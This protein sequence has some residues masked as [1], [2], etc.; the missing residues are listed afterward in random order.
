[1][2]KRWLSN[3]YITLVLLFLYFP[4]SVLVT[5]SFNNSKNQ[6]AWSSFTFKWY[7]NILD[8]DRLVAALITTFS[9]AIISTLIS[10]LIG[11]FS[12]I[13]IFRMR[14][15]VKNLMLTV[16]NLPVINPDIVT[17]VS[18]MILF[19]ALGM[20]LGFVSMLI[21]HIMFSIPFVIISILPKLSQLDRN[22]F[23]AALD[24]GAT[25]MQALRKVIIPV[26]KPGIISGALI[27]FTMSIDDF[28]ISYFTTGNG[29]NNLSIWIYSQ[30]KKGVNPTANAVSTLMLLLI[31]VILVGVE[32]YE[33]KQKE[34]E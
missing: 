27:A 24:L 34:G 19:I 9:I 33:R 16:N 6:Y 28:V 12:A 2:V 7:A 11:T 13:G 10:T 23:E 3:A 26:I 14:P 15:R 30:T 4:I 22:L 20:S 25:P 29:V 8:N 32:I 21:A 31:A 18:L 1:M 17:G 5:Y